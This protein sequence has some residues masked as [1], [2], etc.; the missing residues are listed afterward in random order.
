M[1]FPKFFS[2]RE[3][4]LKN[5]SHKRT[6]WIEEPELKFKKKENRRT[7]KGTKVQ[8]HKKVQNGMGMR[9]KWIY[10]FTIG[11]DPVVS[12]VGNYSKIEVK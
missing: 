10:L 4:K 12:K 2:V 3:L 6:L 11:Y 9:N 5:I 8:K 1:I 7:P